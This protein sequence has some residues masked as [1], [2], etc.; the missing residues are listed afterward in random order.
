MKLL[1]IS[2]RNGLTLYLSLR[3][4]LAGG[5]HQGVGGGERRS[6]WVEYIWFQTFLRIK[7]SKWGGEEK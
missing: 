4:G 5:W 7:N 2:D 3:W 1:S 6:P